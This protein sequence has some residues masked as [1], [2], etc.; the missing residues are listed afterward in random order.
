MAKGDSLGDRMKDYYEN[1]SRHFLTRRVPV[2]MRLDGKAFHTFTK[3]S[4]KPFDKKI[5]E[6]MQRT[7]K[8]LVEEIQGAKVGYVQSDE[9]SILIT[10]YDTLATDA[11]FGYNIQKMT[12]ISASMASVHF[13]LNWNI[14]GMYVPGFKA[15]HFD[16][17]VFN[18]PKEDVINYFRWR[19]SDWRRNSVSMLAQSL[20]SQK[21]LQGKNQ[22]A[23][24]AMSKDKGKDWEALSH[25]ERHGTLYVRTEEGVL[26]CGN[27]NGDS[28]GFSFM[29]DY[30]ENEITRFLQ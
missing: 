29:Y 15:A 1:I 13:T 12:S 3:G 5:I 9:I 26:Q 24:L 22:A 19:Q 6:T 21:E 14:D 10:D 4:E 16:S 11:W 2:I 8:Y 27:G 17:R 25:E 20:Y 30:S 23:M 18:I 28:K 7:T